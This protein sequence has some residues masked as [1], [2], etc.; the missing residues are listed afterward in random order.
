MQMM[1]ID[2]VLLLEPN[3]NA[4]LNKTNASLKV[5][6]EG[7]RRAKDTELLVAEVVQHFVFPTG[8]F[9]PIVL[10]LYYVKYTVISETSEV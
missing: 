10:P 3:I 4:S 2:F 6:H 8:Y 5:P 1:Q 9:L 7:G